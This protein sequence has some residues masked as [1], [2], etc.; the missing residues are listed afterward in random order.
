VEAGEKIVLAVCVL[1]PAFV[2]DRHLSERG[3]ASLC[4]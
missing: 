1:S 2:Q 4:F 3:N